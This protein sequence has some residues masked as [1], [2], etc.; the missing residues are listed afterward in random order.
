[1]LNIAIRAARAG[2][3]VILRKMNRL[4]DIKVE[5]KAVN[6]FVSEVDRLAEE[7]II[8]T[9]LKSYP[10][11][12]IIAE[13]SGDASRSDHE[14]IWII[15]P[16]DGT[17]NFLHGLPHFAVSIACQHKGKIEHAV[18]YDPIQQEIFS[19]SR[20]DGAMLNNK[21]IRV[22]TPRHIQGTLLSTGFPFKRKETL[23]QAMETFKTFF[24]KAGDIRR[25][26]SAALDLAYVASG[27]LD[28]YWESDLK[29]WDIAAGMLIV[30]EAGGLCAD[31]LGDNKSLDNGQ[32][33]AANPKVFSEM[34]RIIQ[35]QDQT[36]TD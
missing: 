21:R 26:G 30:R 1:M 3:D 31:F 22:S 29:S 16:L 32:I 19:A 28:G 10:N 23:D 15:D 25:T 18:V 2:G 34:L 5:Q 12:G 36:I 6:D 14:T 9:L 33:I 4:S 24:L 7:K 8:D 27:R 11:H 35:R 20:G 13:E 17:T